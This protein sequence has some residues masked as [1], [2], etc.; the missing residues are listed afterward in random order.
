[1]R[2]NNLQLCQVKWAI[3][4][5]LC[6]ATWGVTAPGRSCDRLDVCI[7]ALAN[8]IWFYLE[9]VIDL[10]FISSFNIPYYVK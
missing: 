3:P 10:R 8:Y 9:C 5:T 2:L 6:S 4:T 7:G 1:M